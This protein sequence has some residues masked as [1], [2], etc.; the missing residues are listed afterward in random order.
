MKSIGFK[1]LLIFLLLS[2]VNSPFAQE[3]ETGQIIF[4][5]KKFSFY[6]EVINTLPDIP[7][8][9]KSE[10]GTEIIIIYTNKENYAV[11][12]VTVENGSILNY[13]KK[14]WGKGQQ[15]K[16]DVQDFPHLAKTGLHSEEE[17][18]QTRKITGKSVAEIT[19]TGRPGR[20][21]GAGF[22]HEK[23]DIISV[24]AGDNNLVRKLGLTHPQTARPL[25]HIWNMIL[26]VR[27][28]K[29]V[30]RNWNGIKFVFY[31]G[32]KV[33]IKI[34][35]GRG[36]QESIFNDDILGMYQFEIWREPDPDEKEF[37]KKRYSGLNEKQM[38][39]LIKKLSHFHTGEMSPYYIMRY[40]FYEG[41]TSY[42]A[43]PVTVSFVFS[44]KSLEEIDKSFKRDLY[45]VLTGQFTK[46]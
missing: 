45:Q 29:P 15:L 19:F 9:Y 31:N 23:E 46:K 37:L 32:K 33:F 39:Q 18:E 26:L 7:S 38:N 24:L 35:G 22:M 44:L 27:E 14:L 13:K 21:S 40:G 10:N 8:P 17:L 11:V 2:I 36:W 25:F 42:R 12:P 20:S 1:V 28:I 34:Q 41:H 30:G 16:V 3:N 43:D 6:P 4:N 5:K